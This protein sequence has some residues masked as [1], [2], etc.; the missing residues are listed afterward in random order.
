MN[1]I[2]IEQAA[3]AG[4]WLLCKPGWAS[5]LDHLKIDIVDGEAGPW[6]HLWSPINIAVNGVDPIDLSCA[7]MD[8]KSEE[9]AEYH[10]AVGGSTEYLAAKM[11][12]HVDQFPVRP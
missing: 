7:Q 4:I 8:Y 3:R 5:I 1:L 10:G 9:W 6:V 11:M 12:F 2:S